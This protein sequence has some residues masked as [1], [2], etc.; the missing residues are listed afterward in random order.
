MDVSI[1]VCHLLNSQ[2]EGSKV[3]RSVNMKRK[4][5]AVCVAVIVFFVNNSSLANITFG[6]PV[7][8]NSWSI[9][10]D[11]GGLP[12]F[13]LVGAKISSAGD[14]FESPGARNLSEPGWTLVYDLPTLLSATGPPTSDISAVLYFA[15]DADK[16]VIL[17]FAFLS[18]ENLI[19]TSRSVLV[20]GQVVAG[21]RNSQYWTPTRAALIP[22]PGA[23]L[24]GSIGV[25]LVSW[26]RRRK[27]L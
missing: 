1:F 8:G 4:S 24:L 26:L 14:T 6:Q 7:E 19:Y 15:N 13:D 3:W 9:S 10:V 27:T 16:D 11:A 5:I 18:G 22:A 2:D 23:I 12:P 21:E 25:G 17:D 20:N